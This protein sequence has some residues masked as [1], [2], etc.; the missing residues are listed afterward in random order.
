MKCLVSF[1]DSIVWK[2][3]ADE[4][5]RVPG[6]GFHWFRSFRSCTADPFVWKAPSERAAHLSSRY[7]RVR[8]TCPLNTLAPSELWV[9]REW[10]PRR[11]WTK[12]CIGYPKWSTILEEGLCSRRTQFRLRTS[13]AHPGAFY[14]PTTTLTCAHMCCGY[15]ENTTRFRPS[16]TAHR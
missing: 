7:P 2:A 12:L 5:T 3:R 14:W 4:P 6:S 13:S 16:A 9:P 8:R 11:T 15:S 1:T 10:G